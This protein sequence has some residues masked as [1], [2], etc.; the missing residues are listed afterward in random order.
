MSFFSMP[1]WNARIALHRPRTSR[2]KL[3]LRAPRPGHRWVSIR[4][5]SPPLH[6]CHHN[7]EALV[8]EAAL[9]PEGA[10]GLLPLSNLS[11]QQKR[12]GK[13]LFIYLFFKQPNVVNES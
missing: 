11:T 7:S 2:G 6:L 12:T 9:G 5:S 3:P 13:G 8:P 1:L 4:H 10:L